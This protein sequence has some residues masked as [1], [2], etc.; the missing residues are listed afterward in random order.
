MGGDDLGSD[1]E[2]LNPSVTADEGR[3]EAL[4]KA[5]REEESDSK[6]RKVDVVE[7]NNEEE[8]EDDDDMPK[9]K[10]KSSTRKLIEAAR[11]LSLESAEVQASFLWT[12]LKHHIQMKGGSVDDLTKLEPHHL[13][14]NQASD[15]FSRLRASISMKKLKNWKP[16]GTPMVLIVCVSARRAVSVLKELARIKVPVAKLFAKHMEISQQRQLLST[17]AFGLAVGTPNRIQALCDGDDTSSDLS[18]RSTRLV[19]LDSHANQKGFTV[20]TLPD[21]APE[22]MDLVSTR[23]LPQLK[24][25]KDIK[26]AIY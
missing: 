22:T 26:L 11:T 18:L 1:D 20:F 2:Y 9:K 6:K 3:L 23:V 12:T 19:I 4:L 8:E 14:T 15:L 7:A 24:K 17:K 16:I 25:R 21:T 10:K 5:E 13:A